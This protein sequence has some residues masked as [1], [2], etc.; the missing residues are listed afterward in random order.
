MQRNGILALGAALLAL[1]IVPQ[2]NAAISVG[3]ARP[4]AQSEVHQATFDKLHKKH[5]KKAKKHKHKHKHKKHKK[6]HHHH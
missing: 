1:L 2:A 4:V 5:A 3:D 6:H